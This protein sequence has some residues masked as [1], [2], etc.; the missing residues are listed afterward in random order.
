MNKKNKVELP[1]GKV[2]VTT[3]F[4]FL[5]IYNISFKFAPSFTS[6][7]V[8][9]L[10]LAAYFVL[11]GLKWPF[12]IGR[13]ALLILVF[14]LP[15]LTQYLF[16]GDGS[17][18]SRIFHLFFYS[19]VGASL[20]AAL[21][22]SLKVALF[23]YTAAVASQA[24]I[25]ISAFFNMGLR[26][27]FDAFIVLSSHYTVEYMYRAPGFTSSG[28]ADLS[29]IQATGVISGI[30]LLHITKSTRN[31]LQTVILFSFMY[32]CGVS[33]IFVG[34]TGLLISTILLVGYTFASLSVFKIR[35]LVYICL[36]VLVSFFIITEGINYISNIPNFSGEYFFSWVTG[37]FIGSDTTVD[38]ISD[39]TIPP[40]NLETIIG[41]GLVLTPDGNFNASGNDSGYV[42]NY[43]SMGLFFSAIFYLF[44][45]YVLALYVKGRGAVAW[46]LYVIIFF[47]EIK[48]PFIFKYMTIFLLMLTYYATRIENRVCA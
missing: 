10:L 34:R 1:I 39:Q 29:V 2:V 16:S 40:I 18:T 5:V 17:Q 20:I 13:H 27:L 41:T 44:M 3:V 31:V 32:I 33:T 24:V 8:S 12:Q 43:Y 14:L 28:G 35:K 42:Q 15:V 26:E 38:V 46:F 11:L 48:E 37:T 47:I 21:A 23:S 36:G 22:G 45:A 4:I 7:R 9:I 30:W 19:F 6:A 25:I